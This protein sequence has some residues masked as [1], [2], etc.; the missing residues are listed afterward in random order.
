MDMA[1][2][3]QRLCKHPDSQD[4]NIVQELVFYSTHAGLPTSSGF[5]S[6]PEDIPE[7][8]LTRPNTDLFVDTD[9]AISDQSHRGI[10]MARGFNPDLESINS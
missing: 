3:L 8:E 1:T 5:Q 2:H 4:I 7:E 6:F 9:P 10:Y